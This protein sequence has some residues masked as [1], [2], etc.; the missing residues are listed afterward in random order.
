MGLQAS[1]RNCDC[2]GGRAI[3]TMC[4]GFQMGLYNH[5]LNYHNLGSSHEWLVNTV[6]E[7][8]GALS[9]IFV[10]CGGKGLSDDGVSLG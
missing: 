5:D 9:D 7:L 6:S 4:K 10:K 2:N 1:S 8:R 3:Y